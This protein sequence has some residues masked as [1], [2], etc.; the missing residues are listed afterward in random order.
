MLFSSGV[1]LFIFLPIIILLYYLFKKRTY[2]NILLCLFSLIFYAWGEPRYIILMIF[3]I[4]INYIM[5]LLIDKYKKNKQLFFIIDII[6]NV[7]LLFYFKYINLTISSINTLFNIN[8]H[9]KNIVLPIGISFYT[10]Q[11]MSYVIDVYRSKV[12]V[13][14]NIINLATYI[15]LFPQLI[16]GPIVRY[17]TIESELSN[18][19]EN[20]ELFAAGIKRFIIGLSKKVIIANN[21]ALIVDT[22]YSQ[23]V[24][25]LGSLIL[26]LSAITYTLQI[27][28]DFSG[29]SDM[30]IGLGKMFGF[31]FLENFDYPY[32]STSV[33]EFWRRWHISLGTWFKEYIY[34]PLGGNR[35]NKVKWIRNTMIVW[36]LTGLWHGASWNYVIW[37]I[38]YGIII[39]IEKEFLKDFI[40]KR[41]KIIGNI[42]TM[43]LVIIGWVIFRIEDLNIAIKVILKMFSFNFI[44]NINFILDFNFLIACVYIIPGIILSYPFIK[45]FIKRINNNCYTK[46]LSYAVYI[47][48]FVFSISL[49][50][51]NTYN[52]FIYFRF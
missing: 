43:L 11:I 32:I 23:P 52:P 15:V 35:C 14:K 18:R 1:F 46:I 34:I 24:E 37:G 9:S 40:A 48:L 42:I 31:N 2:R 22:I 41:F 28:F 44:S 26:W 3:S 6:I 7:A 30:A 13:Q 4:V 25:N 38:Y 16:A 39:I 36:G 33:S 50:F 12:K 27:Y 47:I 45:N 51:A 49:L 10:F 21:M 20:M 17:E 29:Y 19:H 8:I 5:A